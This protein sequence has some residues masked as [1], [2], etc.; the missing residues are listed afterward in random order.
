M[1][2]AYDLSKLQILVVDDSELMRQLISTYLRGL[3]VGKVLTAGDGQE[4]LKILENFE[5]DIVFCDWEME[6]MSG[7]EFTKTI[8]NPEGKINPYLPIIMVTGHS[9]M[10]RVV[11]A[12]NIGVTEFMVKPLTAR[13]IYDRI[14]SV[15]EDPREFTKTEDY[16]GPDRRQSA[17]TP[18]FIRN[19]RR[20]KIH[21]LALGA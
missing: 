7:I 9:F 3:R 16:F 1:R 6:P 20:R 17:I 14:V 5:A 12:R 4:A 15:I 13:S 2:P 10:S 19:E 11:Q 18:E 21:E 8:R